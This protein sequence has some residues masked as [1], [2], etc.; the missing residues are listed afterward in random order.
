MLPGAM[1]G[2][3]GRPASVAGD[4][5]HHEALV[6]LLRN[7][8]FRF[9]GRHVAGA[10]ERRAQIDQRR[11]PFRIP[12]VLV[13]A[14]PLHPHRPADRLGEHRGVGGR[15]LVAVAAVAAGAFEIDAAHVLDRH[16][17]H[18]R[19]LLAQIV[20]RLRGRPRRELAV[21]E[22]RDRAGRAGR[23]VGVDGEVV[24]GG[25]F[26]HA[27]LAH[28]LGGV[29][30]IAGGLVAEHLARAHVLEQL[31]LLRQP[32]PFRPARLE[33]ARRLDR[34]PLGLR[35]HAEEIALAHDLHDAGDVLDRAFVDAF[36]LGADRRR[37]DHAAVQHA[38]HA[39]IVDVGEAPGHLGRDVDAR[40]RLADDLVVLR[41]LELRRLGVVELDREHLAADQLA[42]ADAAIAGA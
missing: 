16:R 23:S 24:G 35:H 31:G 32:F 33:L 18:L 26:L 20:G 6:G 28:R 37:P 21:A 40:D 8:E 13:G 1:S 11:R 10:V 14:R 15:V 17:E 29:A 39:Q 2:F 34:G 25:D 9:P 19:E 38:A 7:E 3:A 22:F 30:D 41:V 36:E 42:I 27:L 5:R 12:A 4:Q